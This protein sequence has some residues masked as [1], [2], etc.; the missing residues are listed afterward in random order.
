VLTV[1]NLCTDPDVRDSIAQMPNVLDTLLSLLHSAPDL[2]VLRYTA[3][4]LGNLSACS[5]IARELV[6]IQS[7]M[8]RIEYLLGSQDPS[9]TQYAC[10]ILSNL[11]AD[12][13][14]VSMLKSSYSKFL[15]TVVVCLH[16]MDDEAVL[17]TA[18]LAIGNICMDSTQRH[19]RQDQKRVT[20]AILKDVPR[21]VLNL[22]NR[23]HGTYSHNVR[24]RRAAL[25]CLA[26]LAAEPD[27][28]TL[29]AEGDNF[30]TDPDLMMDSSIELLTRLMEGTMENICVYMA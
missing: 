20:K 25:Y 29:I 23:R 15:D 10:I 27:I 1:A 11:A 4:A 16:K 13:G 24:V 9:L 7:A 5:K 17:E 22:C 28:G 3:N 2:G 30:E 18:C 8:G 12:E 26:R 6:S 14:C 19:Q 21:R